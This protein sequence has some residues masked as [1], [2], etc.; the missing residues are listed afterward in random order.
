MATRAEVS[1]AVERVVSLGEQYRQICEES[2][3]ANQQRWEALREAHGNPRAEAVLAT[4]S[5]VADTSAA[6]VEA[7]GGLGQ[8]LVEVYTLRQRS[9][10][11]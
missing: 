10:R 2:V 1:S 9:D 3:A 4:D 7:L 5:R 6:S 11:E 8:A